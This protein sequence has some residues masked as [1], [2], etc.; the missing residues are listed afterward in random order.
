MSNIDLT[1]TDIMDNVIRLI[2]GVGFPIVVSGAL[3]WFN[4]QSLENQTEMLTE[5]QRT[6]TTNIHLLNELNTE[7]SKRNGMAETVIAQ[8]D[9]IKLSM[10]A[11]ERSCTK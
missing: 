3:F 10:A 8:M 11:I 2:N 7:T 6:M 1:K 4:I 5:F 9:N